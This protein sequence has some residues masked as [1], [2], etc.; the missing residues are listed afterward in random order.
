MTYMKDD[1]LGTIA[2]EQAAK[3]HFGMTVDVDSVVVHEIDVA[4]AVTASVYLTK[5]K[6]LLCYIHGHSRLALSDVR[7][8]VARM[9]LKAELYMPPKGQP[10]YFDDVGRAK[11]RD[12]FPGRSHISDEDIQFYR[13]LAPY[14]PALVLI[15]EVK[16]GNIYQF[17]ADA[18][19]GWRIATKFAYRR[20]KTS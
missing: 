6:Q 19:S 13:T 8:I 1:P 20:I 15:A 4:R 14:N 12:V 5:K 9:G 2:L 10:N 3:T 17:D 7:K 16:D 18:R 11:F